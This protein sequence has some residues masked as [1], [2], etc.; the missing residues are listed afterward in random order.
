MKR[1]PL[2]WALFIAMLAL[3]WFFPLSSILH[4]NNVLKR[5]H[6]HKFRLAPLDP[7]D[8]L[9]GEYIVLAFKDDHVPFDSSGKFGVY[10]GTNRLINFKKDS[11][12]FSI[13]QQIL[14]EVPSTSDFLE[15]KAYPANSNSATVVYPFNKWYLQEGAGPEAENRYRKAL[16]I[17]DGIDTSAF[18]LVKIYHGHAVIEDVVI[19]NYSLKNSKR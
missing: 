19:N 12:G 6:L 15:V 3:Q 7:R 18:A 5:G 13:P 16:E 2:I 9:R 17:N 1:Q 8:V 11:L 10:I 4:N 14:S